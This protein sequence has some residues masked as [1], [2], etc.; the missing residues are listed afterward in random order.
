MADGFTKAPEVAKVV[1]KPKPSEEVVRVRL[2]PQRKAVKWDTNVVDNEHLHKKSS[3]ICCIYHKKRSWDESSS[4][5]DSSDDEEN[6]EEKEDHC[7]C[8]D[9]HGHSSTEKGAAASE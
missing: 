1:V 3:K 7:S 2:R 6:G 5:S 9:G 4:D 8:N